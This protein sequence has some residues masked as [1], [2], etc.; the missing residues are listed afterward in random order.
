MVKNPLTEEKAILYASP[1]PERKQKTH[2]KP[3]FLHCS[4]EPQT[5]RH[6]LEKTSEEFVTLHLI[7]S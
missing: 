6:F 7:I 4:F 1:Y 3:H 5:V 2:P